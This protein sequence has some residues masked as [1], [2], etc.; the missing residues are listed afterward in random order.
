[1]DELSR[2]KKL[3][4][5]QYYITGLTYREIQDNTGVSNGSI[6]AIVKEL[7]TGELTIPGTSSDQIDDLV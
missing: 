7:E 2:A 1:M 5:A 6:A 3:E 4:V